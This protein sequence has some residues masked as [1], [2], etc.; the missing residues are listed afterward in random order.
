MRW[1]RSLYWRTALGVVGFLAAMLVV[2]AMLFVWA[3]SQTG[4]TLP[5]QSPLRLASTVALDLANLLERDPRADVERYVHDQYAQYTHP[6]FVML[7]DGRVI[8]SGS[9]SFPEPLLRMAREQ[10]GRRLEHPERGADRWRFERQ[11]GLDA[12]DGPE[13]QERREGQDAREGQE[14]RDGPDRTD[15]QQRVDGPNRRDGLDGRAGLEGPRG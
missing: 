15:G 3:V 9:P 1:H 10:L 13:S 11:R 14:R 4:R 2:Q 8:T 6:F 7:A 5:G 12:R